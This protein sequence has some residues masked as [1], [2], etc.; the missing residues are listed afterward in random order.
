[1]LS[2]L[3]FVFGVFSREE[4]AVLS[5]KAV[6]TFRGEGKGGKDRGEEE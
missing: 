3:R 6:E 5:E 2:S 4:V 1:M